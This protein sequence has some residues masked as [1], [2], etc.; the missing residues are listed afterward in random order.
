MALTKLGA[1]AYRSG[2]IIQT[3]YTQFTGTN[4]YSVTQDTET[5]LTDLTVNITP[6]FTNSIIHLQAHIFCE[7]GAD[8]A[9]AWNHVFYFLRDSTKLAQAAS[10]NRN[11]GLSMATRTFRDADSG[12]T[13]EI[14]R[15]DYF[16][17]PSSTSQI[18][19][20]VAFQANHSNET[21]S[22]NRTVTDADADSNE[23]GISC[24]IAQEIAG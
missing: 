4:T 6:N 15:F 22:L 7:F 24:I 23:R 11:V 8:L 12:S 20:K 18:T 9:N 14:A 1:G 10:S 17:S 19:Y 16:D 13:P 3:Q 21:F 5:I 2:S